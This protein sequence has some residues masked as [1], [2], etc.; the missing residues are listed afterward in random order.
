MGRDD[1]DLGGRREVTQLP[2]AVVFPL[3]FKAWKN[4]SIPLSA[5]RYRL[6]AMF[7]G[8]RY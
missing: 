3:R 7:A 1:R 4:A 8:R 5:H 2:V 6:C